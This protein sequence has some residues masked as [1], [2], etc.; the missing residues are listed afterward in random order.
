MIGG[1]DVSHEP[2]LTRTTSPASTIITLAEAKAHLNVDHDEDDA[3][4]TALVAAVDAHLDGPHG[5]VGMALNQQTWTLVRSA[6][7]GRAGVRLPV[8]P[9]IAVTGVIY[10][11]PDQSAQTLP[12]DDLH[13]FAADTW[14]YVEPKHG[15][16]W[17]AMSGERD[18]LR[19]TFTAGAGCPDPIKHAAKLLVGHWYANREAVNIGNI[20]TELPM[21]VNA[22]IAGC[23]RGWI[24]G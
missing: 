21:A 24:G 22:L 15:E 10:L 12:I 14:A 5:A 7:Q 8:L 16:T 4:I 3:Y 17:P 6:A 11:D 20:T 19:I 9:L 23:R 2:I 13:W 1:R 18:A